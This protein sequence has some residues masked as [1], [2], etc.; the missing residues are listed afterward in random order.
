MVK[1]NV[2]KKIFRNLI[3]GGIAISFFVSIIVWLVEYSRIDDYV[4]R[5]AVGESVK[6]SKYYSDYSDNPS[7]I[8]LFRLRSVL[9]NAF[10]YDLFIFIE[11]YDADLTK[12]IDENKV[13]VEG[14]RA[15]LDQRFSDF[16]MNGK[17]SHQKVLLRGQ[18]YIKVMSP[19]R[20]Q[21]NEKII[22]HFEGVYHVSDDKIAVIKE[23]MF[24]SVSQAVLIVL[25]TAVLL[26]P[27]IL[28]LNKKLYRLSYELLESNIDTI[29]SLGS[30][31]AKRDNDTESHNY[32]VAI[33]S[34]RLAEKLGMDGPGIQSL[35]K[36]AFLHDIGK[37]GISDTILLKPGRLT[38]AEFAIMKQHVVLGME[39]IENNKWLIDA[40]DV[41]MSH[42]EKF[43][44]SGY[45]QGLND[46]KIPVNAK[47]FAI[48][49]VF[50]A[51]T[52]S[53]PYKEAYSFEK[54][55]GILRE[56]AGAHF[57]PIILGE[58][59]MIAHD[60][61]REMSHLKSDKLLNQNLDNLV[62]RYFT[63]VD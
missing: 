22:G 54:A 44:G 56:G 58:F 27:I 18:F 40:R 8:S 52:S 28:Q 51:L 63:L 31:I 2:N 48:A 35:L 3:L 10:G 55:M 21:G 46:E 32:R 6:Y 13:G 14:L 34:V 60:V 24:L 17:V 62:S 57:N 39:I 4:A 7:A 43:D 33:Y 11:I 1:T 26:Y 16:A 12:I 19:I 9:Q 23:Q 36:G 37:I 53:R 45:P 42:H 15:D 20:D 49:D 38:S 59:E 50:D 25:L 61:Y 5:L 30:A 29:K 47:I 41:V